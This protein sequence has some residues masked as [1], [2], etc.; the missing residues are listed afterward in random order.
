MT[1]GTDKW[2][3]RQWPAD[4]QGREA[5]PVHEQQPF[6]ATLAGWRQAHARRAR[7]PWKPMIVRRTPEACGVTPPPPPNPGNSCREFCPGAE[8]VNL[9]VIWSLDNMWK[10][11]ELSAQKGHLQSLIP[12]VWG[13]SL[14]ACRNLPRW[15]W[16]AGRVES[17]QSR[18][19][20]RKLNPTR[21][22]STLDMGLRS[23]GHWRKGKAGMKGFWGEARFMGPPAAQR[24]RWG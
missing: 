16:W 21:R 5:R 3:C 17:N 10:T 2:L 18:E 1:N 6:A 14:T 15:C 24:I 9:V 23:R 20:K 11:M 12:L 4:G 7:S 19:E 8:D 22:Q 13:P